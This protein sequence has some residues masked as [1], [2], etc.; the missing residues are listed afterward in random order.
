MAVLLPVWL[1]DN[2]ENACC[3]ARYCL[4]ALVHLLPHDLI[5][6]MSC[7]SSLTY[8]NHVTLYIVTNQGPTFWGVR[9]AS[10]HFSPNIL[11][12]RLQKNCEQQLTTPLKKLTKLPYKTPPEPVIGWAGASSTHPLAFGT[13]SWEAPQYFL[14]VG[15]CVH[16]RVSVTAIAL[17]IMCMPGI[18]T[19]YPSNLSALLQYHISTRDVQYFH[20]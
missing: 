6:W 15:T 1:M 17:L 14:Q 12:L 13:Q 20:C 11:A 18:C 8:S 2:D 4:P 5:N 10:R 16:S 9:G 19:A 3:T 7:S